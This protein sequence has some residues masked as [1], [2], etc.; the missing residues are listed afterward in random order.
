MPRPRPFTQ[1]TKLLLLARH[2]IRPQLPYLSQPHFIRRPSPFD[3]QVLRLLSTETKRYVKDQAW[4]AARWTAIGWTFLILAGIS[5]FGIQIEIDERKNPTPSEW[6]FWTKNYVRAARADKEDRGGVGIVDWAMVGSA[7]HGALLRLEGEQDGKGLVEQA[8]GEGIDIPDVGRA[9]LDITEKSWEWRAGYFE[10]IMGCAEAAQHLD[11]M[12]LDTTRDF[13]YPKEIVIGPSNPDPRPPAP[14]MG[15]APLEENTTKAFDTPESFYMRV[16]TGKGFSTKQR[17]EASW[18]FAA[19]LEHSGLIDSAEEMYKWGIDIAKSAVPAPDA[20]LDPKTLVIRETHSKLTATGSDAAAA[21]PNILS[22]VTKL[23]THRAR[24]GDVASALPILLSVLRAHHAAPVTKIPSKR[25]PSRQQ[26][27]GGSDLDAAVSLIA[28]LFV[29]P[30]FPAPPPSG[31]APLLR[32]SPQPT[33]EEAELMMYV[34][35]ILFATSPASDAGL[36]WTKQATEIAVANLDA[37]GGKNNPLLS[38]EE[39]LKC[40]SCMRAGVANWENML[41]ELAFHGSDVRSREGGQSA[42]W[43]EWRGWFGGSGGVK[44]KVLDQAREGFLEAEMQHVEKLKERIAKEMIG[45]DLYKYRG[46]GGG[47]VWI[48]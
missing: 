47:G 25:R 5:Y 7:Y 3:Q 13:V 41:L 12:V 27:E 24:N 40:K 9:G 39:R 44:G 2:T 38:A 1:H 22:A 8:D 4:L 21:T 26:L 31:D 18:K 15:A 37:N 48:G 23:A 16:L 29:S 43:F 11:D 28:S 32:E 20:V 42:G 19:W 33:C 6:T 36:S 17:L 14:Y 45:E 10:V 30:V 35:E 34:G 46:A